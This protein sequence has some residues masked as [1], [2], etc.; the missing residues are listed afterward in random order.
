MDMANRVLM[1]MLVSF[2]ICTVSGPFIIPFLK[3]LKFGQSILE[4]GPSWHKSK[5]GTPTM[6]GLMFII[7]ITIA[8]LL[9]SFN[10]KTLYLVG[11][12]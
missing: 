10:I 8:T 9:Y 1:A 4:I 5:S 2:I 11:F 3:R 7:S 12:S 6:G